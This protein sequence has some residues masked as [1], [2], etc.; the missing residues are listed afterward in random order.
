MT[1]AE[2]AHNVEARNHDSEIRVMNK[3]MEEKMC[4]L[5]EELNNRSWFQ[6][7]RDG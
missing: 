2:A 3:L 5:K 6:S 4:E 7:E 1:A